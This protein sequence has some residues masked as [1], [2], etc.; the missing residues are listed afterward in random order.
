MNIRKQIRF[1]YLYEIVSGLQIVD[2]VWVLLLLQRGFSLAEAG[3]AEGVFHLVSMCCEIPSGMVA[4]LIGRKKSMVLA[5][6]ISA[7]A[8]VCMI[9]TDFFPMILLSMGLNA[10]S[11]NLVSGSR[12]A[13]TYDSLKEAKMEQ[14]Y[15][16]VASRQE[17]IYQIL[18]AATGLLSVLTVRMGFRAAYLLAAVQG[19]LCAGIAAQLWEAGEKKSGK[20]QISWVRKDGSGVIRHFR[21][22]FRF[23]REHPLIRSRMMAAG[24]IGAAGY[25]L[26]MLLQEYLV[27]LGLAEYL[28]GIPLF[29][30]SMFRATGAFLSEKTGKRTCRA[31]VLAGGLTAA[32]AATVCGAGSLFAVVVAASAVQC[33]DEM[34]CLRLENDNQKESDSRIRATVVSVG[35]MVYSVWMAVLSPVCGYAARIFSVPAAFAGL[36]GLLAGLA[37][38]YAVCGY[39]SERTRYPESGENQ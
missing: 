36:G 4:D 19:I 28:V 13:L 23:L 9:V 22:S 10:L 8:A 11:Y 3:I 34:I 20:V 32:A 27:T 33:M 31:V 37:V 16:R 6:M 14:K 26:S 38:W 2:L 29:F 25:L 24:G 21:I 15:L 30:I 35:S 39:R 12:E 5:G 7:L 1:L 18:C 17:M